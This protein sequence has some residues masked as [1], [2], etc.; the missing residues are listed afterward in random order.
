MNEALKLQPE[1]AALQ[2][3][4]SDLEEVISLTRDLISFQ[5][6][7]QLEAQKTGKDLQEGDDAGQGSVSSC[8]LCVR[9]TS[10]VVL[11]FSG[12]TFRGKKH[13]SNELKRHARVLVLQS[14]LHGVF[15]VP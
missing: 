1:E 10:A 12:S 11:S 5:T 9:S 13:G 15:K 14:V 4:K 2:K 7:A 3:L 8:P 6:Q